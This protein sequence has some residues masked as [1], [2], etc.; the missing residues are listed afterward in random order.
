MPFNWQPKLDRETR[1][2]ILKSY[3]FI[4]IVPQSGLFLYAAAGDA[5]RF[6]DVF[7]RTWHTVPLAVRRRLLKHWRTPSDAERPVFSPNIQL[8]SDWPERGRFGFAACALDGH[9]LRFWGPLADL[10]PDEV[11]QSAIAHELGHAYRQALAAVTERSGDVAP[12]GSS[13]AT[14]AEETSVEKLV[15][16]WGFDVDARNRWVRE[17]WTEVKSLAPDNGPD[18]ILSFTP[19][20]YEV[21][22]LCP[23]C[24]HRLTSPR[25]TLCPQCGESM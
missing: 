6:A 9:E 12:G 3:H 8:L 22:C 21:I 19:S 15:E 5:S 1:R 2:R 23:F 17:H 10:M 14:D 20:G 4:P 16:T 24:G 11:V 18:L 7:R 13:W 25:E